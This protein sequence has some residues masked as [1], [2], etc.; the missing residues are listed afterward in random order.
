MALAISKKS[1][2]V[3]ILVM[4]C[5]VALLAVFA[6][7]P[8]THAVVALAGAAAFTAAM[9]LWLGYSAS[10]GVALHDVAEHIAN[11]FSQSVKD[12]LDQ[13]TQIV[14][15]HLTIDPATIQDSRFY[16][17]VVDIQAEAADLEVTIPVGGYDAPAYDF[18][19]NITTT[20]FSFVPPEDM[21]LEPNV[22]PFRIV[23]GDV[24]GCF[25]AVSS[26]DNGS[27]T[28]RS[29]VFA[30]SDSS[31]VVYDSK[32][33]TNRLLSYSY[34]YNGQTVYY[35]NFTLSGFFNGSCSP[36][37][38]NQSAP[39]IAWVMVYGTPSGSL[40]YTMIDVGSITAQALIEAMVNT[41]NSNTPISVPLN[42]V[43][44]L[45]ATLNGSDVPLTGS[46]ADAV[47]PSSFAPELDSS[48]E[49]DN[50]NIFQS[51]WDWL[52]SFWTNLTETITGAISGVVEGVNSIVE[53]IEAILEAVANPF[54]EFFTNFLP[55][56]WNT[57]V[58]TINGSLLNFA[59]IWHYVVS[60]VGSLGSGFALIRS[61][62][63]GL[64][65]AMVV[66]I[67]SS[68]V[69]TIVFFVFKRIFF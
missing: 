47:I 19:N 13:G 25:K 66:P 52:K 15:G 3:K 18:G 34:T 39:Q 5:A 38:V 20:A 44:D 46:Q 65:Y 32:T 53:S 48:L 8:R 30:S 49:I 35:S 17:I 29:P 64:P 6:L 43:P 41:A 33:G 61:V 69:I 45:Q 1:I 57:L 58:G 24:V 55:S 10:S 67:Y 12:L 51:I 23:S 62:W 40:D 56:F 60:W 59:S 50:H 2:W 42:A 68:I 54:A 63:S 22:N 7:P 31:A 11:G 37:N 4:L 27:G 36:W 9:L 21:I 28:Q 16:S 26:S 14:N